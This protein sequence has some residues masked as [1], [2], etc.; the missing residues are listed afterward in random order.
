[1][2]SINR[3]VFISKT[4]RIGHHCCGKVKDRTRELIDTD[5]DDWE[6]R[7]RNDKIAVWGLTEKNL[8]SK[9]PKNMRNIS[10]KPWQTCGRRKWSNRDS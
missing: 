5:A 9:T 10:L 1:M 4:K 8:N 7:G 2:R 3:K 6:S